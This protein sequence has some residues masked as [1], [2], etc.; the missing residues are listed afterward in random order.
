MLPY[1]NS[2]G[3][4]IVENENP[5]DFMLDVCSGTLQRKDHPDFVPSVGG[6]GAT[7]GGLTCAPEPCR[8]LPPRLCALGGGTEGASEQ[9]KSGWWMM[10]GF[11]VGNSETGGESGGGGLGF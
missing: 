9:G 11:R 7:G 8:E 5:A 1:F 10:S 3:F 4:H 6:G 2:I